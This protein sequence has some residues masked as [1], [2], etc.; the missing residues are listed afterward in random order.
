MLE[1]ENEKLKQNLAYYKKALA[2][3]VRCVEM[4]KIRIYNRW[5]CRTA[6]MFSDDTDSDE[7]EEED[8]EED[9]ENEEDSIDDEDD[10]D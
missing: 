6:V 2:T 8:D 7:S 10:D 9:D 4:S 1:K 3:S 5:N